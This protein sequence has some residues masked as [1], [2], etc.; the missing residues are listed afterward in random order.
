MIIPATEASKIKGITVEIGADS[1][2]LMKTLDE[3]EKKLDTLIEKANKLK[4]LLSDC[5]NSADK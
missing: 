4:S 3:V 1:S 5:S 2:G